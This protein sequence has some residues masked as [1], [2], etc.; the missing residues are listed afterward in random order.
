M[1]LATV[2][3]V[4]WNERALPPRSTKVSTV[5]LCAA[6]AAYRLAFQAAD[7]GFINLDRFAL[8]AER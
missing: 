1:T 3:L 4:M 6:A 8:T 2:A 7:V 5:F